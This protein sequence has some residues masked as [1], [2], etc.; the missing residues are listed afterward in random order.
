MKIILSRKGFDSAA[1][2]YPSPL[3]IED[4]RMLS[5]PIPEEN[6]LYNEDT[7][8]RYSDLIYDDNHSYLDIMKELGLKGFDDKCA[9]LDPD[10]RKE[11][12][13]DRKPGWNAIFGQCDAA[14]GHLSANNVEVG[15]LFLFYGWFKEVE[16]RGNKLVYIPGTDKHIIWGYMQ[17]GEIDS[18][19]EDEFYNDWKL[20]HPHYRNRNRINNTGYIA[21]E[22]LR[23]NPDYA[24]YGVFRYDRSLVLTNP[25]STRSIWRLPSFF[26]PSNE[27][28][29]T[30]NTNKTRW[31]LEDDYCILESAK[32]GQEFIISGNDKVIDW[33]KN[34]FTKSSTNQ[35]Q[36]TKKDNT[37]KIEI[38][39]NTASMYCTRRATGE[40]FEV[41]YNL[42]DHDKVKQYHWKVEK[43]NKKIYAVKQGTQNIFLHRL[44]MDNCEGKIVK[45]I[46]G[47]YFDC[48]KENLI[49][50]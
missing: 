18:I 39:Y 47:N 22:Y 42:E 30:Y 40:V 9:H 17:I 11:I 44:I 1:G 4:G 19:V 49:V 15:D 35:I 29:M 46:N 48:R 8:R 2:G 38:S 45:A 50:I 7:G 3:F 33:M 28:K 41:L 26:Y 43:N 20:D 13:A 32:I 34:L 6:K 25:N 24:G 12:V 14:Q 27:T 36:K 16:R 31:A 21:S 10:I 23:F 5:L 37:Q